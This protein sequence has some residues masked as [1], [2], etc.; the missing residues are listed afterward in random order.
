MIDLKNIDVVI[1]CGGL[2]TRLRDEIGESQ[3]TMVVI[4]DRPFLDIIILHLKKQGFKRLIL[5]TGYQ[6]RHVEDYYRQQDLGI[7]IDFS[8]E[9]DPLGTG[10]A[11]K[12]AQQMIQSDIFFVMNGD[13]FCPLGYQ[14]LLAFHLLKGALATIVVHPV[15]EAG[16]FGTVAFDDNNKIKFFYEKISECQLA[17]GA[18]CMVNAGIYCFDRKIFVFMP[19]DPAFSMEQD[20]FPK[21]VD[22]DLFAFEE[23]QP[24][25]DIGTPQRLAEAKKLLATYL[26]G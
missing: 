17:S 3:K 25:I 15:D 8:Q 23:K 22:K 13:S 12:Q 4:D 7:S 6:S 5:C 11:L 9:A 2:G 20:L 16:D 1:L 26:K 24:F 21:L 18:Q 19:P 14:D 10:G